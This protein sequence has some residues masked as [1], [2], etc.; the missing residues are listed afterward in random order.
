MK[1]NVWL[2]VRLGV[3]S[4]K[5]LKLRE[6]ICGTPE[7]IGAFETPLTPSCA[8]MLS[9]NAKLSRTLSRN[10][11]QLIRVSWISRS[12]RFCVRLT[13]RFWPRT[14]SWLLNAG[15]LFELSNRIELKK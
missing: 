13:V 9:L 14:D 7:S 12:V 11:F 10:R 4:P 5:G 3:G 1:R 2:R 6:V 8:A 15:K